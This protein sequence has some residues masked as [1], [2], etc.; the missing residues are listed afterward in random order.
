MQALT[1]PLHGRGSLEHVTEA[2]P[3]LKT[4][5]ALS[6][7]V[8]TLPAAG[9]EHRHAH[10]AWRLVRLSWRW[11]CSTREALPFPS[12]HFADAETQEGTLLGSI[13]GNSYS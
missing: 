1:P 10:N 9:A 4:V 2:A 8:R 11:F 5:T 3:S 7:A 13:V 6:P 12:P